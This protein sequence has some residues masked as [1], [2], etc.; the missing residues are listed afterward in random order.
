LSFDARVLGLVDGYT[1][2]AAALQLF[3]D[4]PDDTLQPSDTDTNADSIARLDFPI[5]KVSSNWQSYSFL[6]SKGA[7]GS[8]SKANFEAAYNKI[9][10]LR[11]Q[12]QIENA[13]A[14]EW[15]YDADNTLVIDNF[16]LERLYADASGPTISA[17]R[18][19]DNLVLTWATPASG[20]VK[21]QAATSV[22]GPYTDVP[23]AT[24]GYATPLTGQAKFF[25]LVQQ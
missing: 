16:K 6:L 14:P 18:N 15:G 25:R 1:N 13:T 19:G 10:A 8:G 21:L 17:A 11:T 20:T 9:N 2:T 4:A 12:W 5:S 3:L 7:F 22:T 24:S 23:N